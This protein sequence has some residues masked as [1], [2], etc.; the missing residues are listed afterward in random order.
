MPL[1]LPDGTRRPAAPEFDVLRLS[2]R[3]TGL[4]DGLPHL[5]GTGGPAFG[6]GDA[7]FVFAKFEGEVP[8]P[9]EKQAP[10]PAPDPA[11]SPAK[12]MPEKLLRG[13]VVL[14]GSS[15]EIAPDAE[16][17][18]NAGDFVFCGAFDS[19]KSVWESGIAQKIGPAFREGIPV[20]RSD[21]VRD[22]ATPRRDQLT[23]TGCR[24]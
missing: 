8:A 15:T 6:E 7:Y 4:A 9:P 10:V 1:R 3:V 22:Y 23:A 19:A 14:T 17:G 21:A 11:P 2:T 16:A 18:A 5:I 13:A 20:K 12:P 24:L